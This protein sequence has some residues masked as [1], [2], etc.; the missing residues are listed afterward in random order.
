MNTMKKTLLV[1]LLLSP[2]TTARADVVQV[3]ECTMQAG[4]TQADLTKASSAWLAGARGV[5][6]AEKI[7]V[8]HEFP[9]AAQSGANGFNF[10]LTAPDTV[11]WGALMNTF[12]GAASA[13]A[14]ADW[15]QVATCSG[16]T[17]WDSAK[18]D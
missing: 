9:I 4:K 14:D 7:N 13:K 5:K 3:W 15:A 6:G 11:A 17:L 8:Y 10:V 18:V 12:Q 16:S 1:A 2:L